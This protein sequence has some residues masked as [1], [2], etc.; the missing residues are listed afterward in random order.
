MAQ[1]AEDEAERINTKTKAA[2]AAA[3]PVIHELQAAEVAPGAPFAG[4]W[5]SRTGE[6]HAGR[7][8]WSAPQSP[9]P[10]LARFGQQRLEPLDVLVPCHDTP[11]A[12][13]LSW[14]TARRRVKRSGRGRE[15]SRNRWF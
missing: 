15:T 7:G 3:L 14:M 10:R 12:R 13:R 9:P 4:P 8:P 5:P 6:P 11:P 2:L 1:V